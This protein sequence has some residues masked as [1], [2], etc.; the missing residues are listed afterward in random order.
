M[1]R[2]A[3]LLAILLALPASGQGSGPPTVGA[4]PAAGRIVLDGALDE[5][6]WAAA[7]VIPELTQQDPKPGEPTPFSTRV[8]VLADG[9]TLYFGITAVDPEPARIAVHTLQRDADLQ[10]DDSIAVVLDTFGDGRTGYLFRINAG[11]ARQD[12]LIVSGQDPSLDWDGIWDA[13]VRRTATGWTAE[14]AIPARSLRFDTS[15]AAWGLNV[16]RFVARER[17]TLRWS[18]ATLDSRLTDLRRAGRLEGVSGLRQGLGLSFSP[19]ALGRAVRRDGEGFSKEDAGFDLSYNLTPQLGAVLTVNTDFAETEVDARQIN[20]T[21]FPLFFPE[22][23]AF[24]LEGSN[25]FEFGSGLSEELIPFYS[26][27]VG[28]VEGQVV[29]LDA[30]L[31]VLGRAGRWS[32]AALDV[33]T[34]DSRAAPAVNLFAGRVTYDVD[35]HLRL[36]AIGTR[37]DPTGRGENALG[38]LDAVWQTSSF[39]GDKNLVLAAWGAHSAGDLPEGGPSGWGARVAYPNDLW[40]LSLQVDEFGAALDPALGFLPRPGTRQYNAGV[41]YQPRPRGDGPFSWVRQFFFECFPSRVDRVDGTTES[42]RV[43]LAP[44]NVSTRSGEHLEANWAPEF[45]RLD[46]PFEIANGV[47]IPPGQYRFNRFRVEAQSSSFRPW[48]VGSTVWLG[49]FFGGHLTQWQAFLYWTIGPGRLRFEL[50]AE[51]DFGYLPQ[52]D[53]I[54]RLLQLKTVY[55]FSPDLVLSVY[56]QYDSESRDLG[57]NSRLRW[58]IQPGRDLFLVW[59]QSWKRL[60]GPRDRLGAEA[61]EIVVKLRWTWLR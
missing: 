51:N 12:G 1:L 36:G 17:L 31:K 60:P 39:Q 50:T 55:A 5:P 25:L 2:C 21:R 7:G 41:A 53:F 8:A 4:G 40:D 13:R 61:N 52:G 37:G 32:I 38:G 30:G 16:E 47:V 11:G 14:I 59:N 45:E 42:W 9:D 46:E 26:R 10:G 24:F 27:R 56:S 23:R 49:T 57:L 28:L 20:L 33:E 18:G 22:K 15:L 43:F 34:G 19:Y 58:T 29:P 6:A 54:Q 3:P 35:A 48:R 44:F